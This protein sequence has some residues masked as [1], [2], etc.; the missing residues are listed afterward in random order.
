M[1]CQTKQVTSSLSMALEEI[2]KQN[3]AL[4]T[5]NKAMK[6]EVMQLKANNDK[7][8]AEIIQLTTVLDKMSSNNADQMQQINSQLSD[9]DAQRDKIM[10]LKAEV[11]HLK[12]SDLIISVS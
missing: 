6:D 9:I 1:L 5:E 2:R 8:K 7:Q 4:K 10:Q 3:D 11:Q 12:V